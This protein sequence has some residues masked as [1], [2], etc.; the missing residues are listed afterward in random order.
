MAERD[1]NTDREGADAETVS[2]E[3][4]E[5]A[6]ARKER[7]LPLLAIVGGVALFLAI[8]Y[9]LA[10]TKLG[11]STGGMK[12]KFSALAREEYIWFLVRQNLWILITYVLLGLAAVFLI[13]PVVAITPARR[14][15]SCAALAFACTAALHGLFTLRLMMTRPYF[16]DPAE[17]GKWYYQWIEWIP[18]PAKPTLFL[19]LFTLIPAGL[20]LWAL[21]RDW[22]RLG[23]TGRVVMGAVLILLLGAFLWKPWETDYGKAEVSDAS[24]PNIL[25]IGSDSL[26]A[27]RLGCAGHHPEGFGKLATPGVSPNIDALAERSARFERCYTTIA[28]TIESG[29]QLMASQY[30]HTHGM[31]QMYPDRENVRQTNSTV[32][33]LAGVLRALGYETAAIGDW[34]AGYY[35]ITPLGFEE[36]SVSSFDN[37]KIY[38]SQAVVMAHFVVPLYFDNDLGYRLFPQLQ[39]FAQFVTPEVVTKRVERRLAG[40]AQ[41]KR[42]F[43]WHVF[44][45]CNHL[46]YRSKEPYSS[47]FT[48]PDYRGPNQNGVDFDI[49]SFIGGTDVESK[50]QALPESE[51]AQ[52]R[53]LYDGCTRQFDDC[54]GRILRALKQH[55]LED[56]TIV[57]V[58]SDHGDDLYEPGVTL[59]HGLTF[60]GGLHSFH[61]PMIVHVPGE[62]PAVFEEQIRLLDIAP[63]IADLAGAPVP[64]QW[65]GRSLADWLKGSQ[66]EGDRAFYGETGFPFIQ[67]RVEGVERPQLPP[68]DE[69]TMID[70]SFNYQFVL[71]PE[72]REPLVAAKQRC[73]QTRDWKLVCTPNEDGDRHFGL[74]HLTNDPNGQRN[75][76][77]SR[78]EVL[79]PMRKALELWMDE[80][81]ETPI[82]GIFP[83]GEP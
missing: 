36:V 70:D 69:M 56:N 50:W 41:S 9:G 60:N 55:G 39:S 2:S 42:P 71:K 63:T 53:G 35:E 52:I 49:D 45:S 61:V 77:D 10:L 38:M 62:K 78:P 72:F 8:Q 32:R 64:D 75:V 28:S 22:M 66:P 14:R 44:Y 34:C 43:F 54:V 82:P 80:K 73:L 15:I 7:A 25:I 79:Q 76:A 13:R 40:A 4:T 6:E 46:P 20:A 29:V 83:S 74:F 68:M 16:I 65:E 33:P 26:R 51:V 12:N 57:V 31:R 5:S 58:T 21:G 67:F 19:I 17:F 23:K 27:D 37:F 18:E 48:E 81:R 1:H 11:S 59:G 47:M 24:L 3:L 30:P